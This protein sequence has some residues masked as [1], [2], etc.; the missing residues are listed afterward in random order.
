MGGMKYA[1]P[2]A[3]LLLT[4]GMAGATAPRP[5][6]VPRRDVTV[7]YQIQPAHHDPIDITV[8]IAAGGE[9][10]KVTSITLPTTLLID[11]RAETAAI[12]LPLL[13]AYTTIPIGKYD[14]RN[15]VLNGARFTPGEH[16]H[17][18]GLDC[19]VWHAASADGEA[20]ACVTD[21]GVILRGE[22]ENVNG[23]GSAAVLALRVQYGKVPA[24]EFAIPAGYS[25]SP[26]RRNLD[27]AS[28]FSLK[29]LRR[30]ND[31]R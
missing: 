17:L 1:L 9:R 13:R 29:A 12:I 19:T 3:L 28:G 27:G 25:E 5:L 11:R 20:R 18:A 4:P 8:A 14:P 30:G 2:A 22:A 21:D 10:L 31:D 6:L 16:R 15:T 26:I 24:A 23:K 7:D